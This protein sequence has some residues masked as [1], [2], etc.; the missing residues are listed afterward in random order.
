MAQRGSRGVALLILTSALD[1]FVWSASRPGHFTPGKGSH[2]CCIAGWLGPWGG[3][4]GYGKRKYLA[5]AG[6][7]S[8]KRIASTICDVRSIIPELWHLVDTKKICLRT[9]AA[10]RNNRLFQACF[11]VGTHEARAQL[12]SLRVTSNCDGQVTSRGKGAVCQKYICDFGLPPRCWWDLHSSG[13][14]RSV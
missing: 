6:T 8:L 9:E 2:S 13:L 10:V 3:L 1:G 5:S 14:L 11:W 4:D 12:P 7:R